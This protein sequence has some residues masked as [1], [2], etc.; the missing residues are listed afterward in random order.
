MVEAPPLPESDALAV[1]GTTIV[2]ALELITVTISWLALST[3]SVTFPPREAA[4][5]KVT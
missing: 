1:T 4:P 3:V 5:L 2:Y